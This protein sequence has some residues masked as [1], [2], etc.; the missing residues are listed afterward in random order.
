MTGRITSRA[1]VAGLFASVACASGSVGANEAASGDLRADV[2]SGQATTKARPDVR[3][4]RWPA[5]NLLVYREASGAVV[6]WFATNM[7]AT[8]AGRSARQE[9]K[10]TFLPEDVRV[11]IFLTRQLL[12]L[13]GPP[14][15]GDTASTVMSGALRATDGGALVAGRRRKKSSLESTV[16]LV[17]SPKDRERA[18]LFELKPDQVVQLV[19]AMDS[20]AIGS[21]YRPGTDSVSEWSGTQV[22][23]REGMHGVPQYPGH[24]QARGIEGEVWLTFV[25]EADGSVDM[26]S[27]RT[28]LSDHPSFERSVHDYLRGTRY[29]PATKGGVAVRQSVAQRFVFGLERPK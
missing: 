4:V 1:A 9:V 17:I 6:V 7:H 18:L 16:R 12:E 24:L 8:V 23:M 14:V 20:A 3:R 29:I 26:E 25:V 11:W 15:P 22:W 13:D 21:V 28:W 27:L 10:S 2:G 5:A 19:A